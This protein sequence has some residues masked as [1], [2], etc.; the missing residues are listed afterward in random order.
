MEDNRS[1][2]LERSVPLPVG[3][4]GDDATEGIGGGI[5]LQRRDKGDMCTARL[6]VCQPFR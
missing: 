2:A 5:R 4:S 3:W 1:R 6:T